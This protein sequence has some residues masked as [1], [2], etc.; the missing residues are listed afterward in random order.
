MRLYIVT[1]LK[2][3]TVKT[4]SSILSEREAQQKQWGED[5]EKHSDIFWSSVLAKQTGQAAALIVNF[6][7]AQNPIARE[8]A[9]RAVRREVVQ[10]AAVAMAW[11]ECIDER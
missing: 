1:Y 11:L 2:A 3:K 9:K 10:I 8:N 5:G 6:L 7:T 4:L